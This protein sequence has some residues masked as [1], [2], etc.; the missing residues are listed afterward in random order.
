[1]APW[2]LAAATDHVRLGAVQ[3]A[4]VAQLQRRPG[5]RVLVLGCGLGTTALLALR[6]GAAHVTAVDAS[7]ALVEK[8]QV[9]AQ[10]NGVKRGSGDGKVRFVVGSAGSLVAP[11]EPYDVIVCEAVDNGGVGEKLAALAQQYRRPAWLRPR[12]GVFMPQRLVLFAQLVHL[13]MPGDAVDEVPRIGPH[14]TMA[15]HRFF[16]AGRRS[17]KAGPLGSGSRR[18]RATSPLT[19]KRRKQR[20]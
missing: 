12:T 20:S 1:M 18:P 13:R 3:R 2:H 16:W 14:P 4:L 15:A 8:A 10:H 19:P 7:P 11:P 17:R 9:L 5:Q 6:A